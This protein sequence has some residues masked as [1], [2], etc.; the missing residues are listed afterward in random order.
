MKIK[1]S[2]L[3]FTKKYPPFFGQ[4]T[5]LFDRGR[6]SSRPYLYFVTSFENI[7]ELA[8]HKVDK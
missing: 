7:Q 2:N 8:P 4:N 1:K 5:K 3:N 6:L